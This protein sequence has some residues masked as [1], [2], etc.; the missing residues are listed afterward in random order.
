MDDLVQEVWLRLLRDRRPERSSPRWITGVMKNV[1]REF[2]R[3]SPMRLHREQHYA[4]A[5]MEAYRDAGAGAPPSGEDVV[6]ELLRPLDLADQHVLRRRYVD[7]ATLEEL[8]TELGLTFSGVKARLHATRQRLRDAHRKKRPWYAWLPLLGAQRPLRRLVPAAA[9]GTVLVAAAPLVD[10]PDTSLDTRASSTTVSA[11]VPVEQPALGAS[12]LAFEGERVALPARASAPDDVAPAAPRA[13]EVEVVDEDGEPVADAHVAILRCAHSKRTLWRGVTGPEGEP[14]VCS[15][16]ILAKL[17]SQSPDRRRRLALDGPMPWDST[18]EVTPELLVGGR[19]RLVAPTE[20]APIRVRIVD[21]SGAPF[22]TPVAVMAKLA[23][24]WGFG[25]LN[26]GFRVEPGEVLEIPFSD[27]TSEVQLQVF[28]GVDRRPISR[29]LAAVEPGAAAIREIEIPIR[30]RRALFRG[31]PRTPSGDPIPLGTRV[32]AHWEGQPYRKQDRVQL[33]P[34]GV[35]ELGLAMNAKVG[36]WAQLVIDA[37]AAGR[38][39]VQTFVPVRGECLDL[40]VIPLEAA[41]AESLRP[42]L[43]APEASPTLRGRIHVP[44]GRDAFRLRLRLM[45][46]GERASWETGTEEG[47]FRTVLPSS[48]PARLVVRTRLHDRVLFT[49]DVEAPPHAGATLSIDMRSETPRVSWQ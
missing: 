27:W 18:L 11:G 5:R 43:K 36:E 45:G 20:R 9:L 30:G 34:D 19:A 25:R 15:G 26:H 48:W 12:D 33:Q 38:A 40:G 49:Q 47:T 7:G 24:D 23:D 42:E 28:A 17:L 8:T 21:G 1:L 32:F 16:D 41:P 3:D 37:G 14:A 10:E 6:Q 2:R 31:T 29:S 22:Q 4:A 13:F 46:R 44:D 39:V 35:L